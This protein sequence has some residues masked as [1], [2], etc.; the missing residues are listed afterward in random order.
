[1]FAVPLMVLIMLVANN[2]KV[3]GGRM[4]GRWTNGLGWLATGAMAAAAVA[5]FATWGS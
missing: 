4:N 5:M 1:M 3:M 2:K